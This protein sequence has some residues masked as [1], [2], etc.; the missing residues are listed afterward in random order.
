MT[1]LGP[2]ARAL[3]RSARSDLAI[4]HDERA[5]LDR[6]LAARLGVAAGVA[7][8][9][10][11]K[12]PTASLPPA[13][14]GG[15]VATALVTKVV[16]VIAVVC[17]AAGGATLYAKRHVDAVPV[18]GSPIASARIA[19]PVVTP[20]PAA[21]AA[22]T[23]S[24]SAAIVAE[25][26]PSAPR[27]PT[28]APALRRPA[29]AAA[30]APAAIAPSGSVADETTLL[31]SADA[32]LRSDDPTRAL[33]FLDEHA[34]KYPHGILVEERSAERIFALC[35]LGRSSEARTDARQFLRDRG[36]SPLAA[37]VRASCGGKDDRP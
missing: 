22:A 7:V 17:V 24:A 9:L 3:F 5:R 18:P 12:G 20:P 33:A 32:A 8:T 26:S 23:P 14:A 25:P 34:R 1:E 35:K 37:S 10:A 15:S 2:D 29:S 27:V 11:A 13:A 21:V 19:P 36:E 28:R 4:T 30:E 16:G 31:R 6:A